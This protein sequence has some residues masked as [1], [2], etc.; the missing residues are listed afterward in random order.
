MIVGC[1]LVYNQMLLS[2]ELVRQLDV[3]EVLKR[4]LLK[5]YI[6]SEMS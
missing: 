3:A 6:I 5:T 1:M 2:R 4:L